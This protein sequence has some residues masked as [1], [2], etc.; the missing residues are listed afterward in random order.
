MIWL[1]FNDV[2]IRMKCMEKHDRYFGEDAPSWSTKMRWYNE[3]QHGRVLLKDEAH[4]SLP[5]TALTP[6][7]IDAVRRTNREDYRIT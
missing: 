7:N 6:E 4:G 2:L 1:R 5:V 3:F